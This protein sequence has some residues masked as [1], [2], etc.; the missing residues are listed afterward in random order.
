[1]GLWSNPPEGKMSAK[2]LS[3]STAC[4]LAPIRTR[5]TAL[6]FRIR[7]TANG[8]QDLRLVG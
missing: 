8:A 6:A 2:P 7:V 1:M 5:T 3:R 4:R